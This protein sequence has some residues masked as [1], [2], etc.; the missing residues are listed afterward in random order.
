MVCGVR[1]GVV[2]VGLNGNV[3]ENESVDV[4][5]SMDV[6]VSVNLGVI[7]SERVD[8]ETDMRETEDCEEIKS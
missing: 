8:L 7:V 6:D 4:S 1:C 3:G 2:S 5:V